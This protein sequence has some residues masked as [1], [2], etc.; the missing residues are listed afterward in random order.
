MFVFALLSILCQMPVACE[1][2][3]QMPHGTEAKG[4]GV[5]FTRPDGTVIFVNPRAVAFVR[6]RLL[7]ERGNATIVFS[8]GQ[9]QQVMESVE[10]VIHGI[11][12]DRPR[13]ERN[14]TGP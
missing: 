9:K 3:H 11:A 13:L 14:D 6:G 8:S 4:S 10:Q 1:L 2:E 5:R 12:I 7:D